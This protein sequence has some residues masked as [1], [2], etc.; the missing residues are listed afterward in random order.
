MIAQLQISDRYTPDYEVP[1]KLYRE[2]SIG[3]EESPP[4]VVTA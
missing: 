3:P 4:D 2:I 1:R